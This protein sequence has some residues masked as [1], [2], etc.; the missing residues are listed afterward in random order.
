MADKKMPETKI[1][2][3]STKQEPVVV[4]SPIEITD[5]TQKPVVLNLETGA[6][7]NLE[8]KQKKWVLR[9]YD[10]SKDG[11]RDQFL[12]LALGEAVKLVQ[13][14]ERQIDALLTFATAQSYQEGRAAALAKGNFLVPELRRKIVDFM[15]TMPK[16][17][18]LKATAAFDLWK[19]GYKAKKPGA[20]RILAVVSQDTTEFEDL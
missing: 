16:F 7:D 13:P 11:P 9:K 2:E 12:K 20:M 8:I 19:E 4:V 17:A 18:E 14:I 10:E 6:D 15:R 3:T 1:Q 5:L